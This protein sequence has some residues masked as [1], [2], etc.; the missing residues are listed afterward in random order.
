MTTQIADELQEMEAELALLRRRHA[1]SES[2][3]AQ[4]EALLEIKS[5]VL[6]QANEELKSNRELLRI[7]LGQRTRQLLEAQRVA[8]FGTMIW[9]AETFKGEL[10]PH[11]RQLLGIPEGVEI[12]GARTIDGPHPILDRVVP[13]ERQRVFDW[14]INFTRRALDMKRHLPVQPQA[15]E[16]T[17]AIE[18]CG[19]CGQ[20]A[21]CDRMLEFRVKGDSDDQPNR[22]IR[23][24][25][26]TSLD[27]NLD[28]VLVFITVQDITREIEAANEAD[29]LRHR[30]QRRMRELEELAQELRT[31]RE[32]ADRANA[33]KTRFLAMMSHDIRTPMN[34]VIGMLALFEDTGLSD[35][36]KEVLRHMRASGDQLRVLLD[37]IIDLEQAESGKL[38]LATFPLEVEKFLETSIGFWAR[39]ARDKGLTLEL[40]RGVYGL[41]QPKWILADRYR[42]RQIVDNL[43]SNA[44]KYTR[45]GEI[46]VRVGVI[47]EGWFRCEVIDSGIGI[48]P[49][50]RAE[51][52]ADFGQLHTADVE[53]GG[54]G[55]GLAI[56][57]RIVELMDGQIGVEAGP[58]GIGSCFWVEMPFVEVDGP[59]RHESADKKVLRRPDGGRP[60]V[61]V[62]EDVETNRIV[63]RGML[64]KLGCDVE[65][66]ADGAEA[67]AAVGAGSF[68]VVLMDMSMPVLDGVEATRQ[69]RSLQGPVN[70][71]PIIAL[72]AYSRQEELAPI[73]TA[74]AM[75]CVKKPIVLDE[76]YCAIKALFP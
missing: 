68:D 71:I 15:G 17:C 54:S 55:L 60:R 24:L 62:A 35:N 65:L 57:R 22:M 70:A 41:P 72:T 34:G 46:Q 28:R 32:A 20:I 37:D 75:G 48:P 56:C 76:L 66:V 50:R 27:E 25:A 44:V 74:G 16:A 52:F 58:G 42:L 19:T 6:A 13:E 49:G 39:A 3:R 23:A 9:D 1:R 12:G 2:A 4:A 21:D 7:E 31:A 29:A 59:A 51:L 69:I 38:T 64:S 14:S 40:H 61:L 11:C 30:D 43:L 53:A 26:E 36:Q 67:V 18:R 5:R 33:A 47:R 63:A 73:L 10:S 8:G 45:R